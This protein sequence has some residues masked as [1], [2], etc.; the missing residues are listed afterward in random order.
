MVVFKDSSRSFVSSRPEWTLDG[1]PL[2]TSDGRPA[3]I[4][5]SPFVWNDGAWESQITILPIQP[6]E[7]DRSVNG[8][9][10]VTPDTL[11]RWKDVEIDPAIEACAQVTDAWR[12]ASPDAPLT[13][14]LL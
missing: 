13:V 9:L 10:R 5:Q 14:I 6:T 2:T 8:M 1:C 3:R 7:S 12:S 4:E 11:R